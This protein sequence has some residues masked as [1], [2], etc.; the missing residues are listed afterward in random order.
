MVRSSQIAGDVS[1][2]LSRLDPLR[3]LTLVS[4]PSATRDME[5]VH[6]PRTMDIVVIEDR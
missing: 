4:G 5:G 3:P 1:E 2:A 6:G